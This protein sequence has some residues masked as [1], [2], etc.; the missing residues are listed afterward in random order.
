[1][2]H[3]IALIAGALAL[4]GCASNIMKNYIGQPLQS[5]MVDYGPPTNAFDMPDGT[6]AFQWS[7]E[8][9]RVTPT[10]ATT[11]GTAYGYGNVVNWTQRTAI[12]GGVPITSRC[13]YTMFARWDDTVQTWMMTSFKKPRLDCE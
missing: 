5:A 13:N 7:M 8:S 4:T 1:M 6:R 10:T 3:R 11:T 9:T 2:V 12:T